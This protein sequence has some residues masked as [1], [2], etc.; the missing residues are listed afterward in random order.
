MMTDYYIHEYIKYKLV[1][2]VS[3]HDNDKNSK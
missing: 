2:G 1:F 3:N